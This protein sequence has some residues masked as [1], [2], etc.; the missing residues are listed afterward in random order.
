MCTIGR[1]KVKKSCDPPQET[2]DR[3][4]RLIRDLKIQEDLDPDDPAGQSG[5]DQ[6]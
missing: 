1:H 3:I 2:L 4:E 5:G 6:Q